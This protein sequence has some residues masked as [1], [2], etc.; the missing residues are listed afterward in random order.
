[1]ATTDPPNADQVKSA[2]GKRGRAGYE[3]PK[4]ILRLEAQRD[5]HRQRPLVLRVLYILVGFTLLLGGIAMLVLP[6][7]AFLVIPVGLALLS[8]EFA[9]AERL[10]D[11]ALEQGE[12]AKQ[13]AAQTTKTQR[14]FTAIAC[15]LATGAFAAWAVFGDVPVL[16]V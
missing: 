8:L 2:R 14:I 12:I 9:W 5:R 15:V 10:L 3:K 11:H 4:I 1:V 7:P 16:P 13:K 6:G